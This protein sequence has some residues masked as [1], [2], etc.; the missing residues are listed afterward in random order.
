ME[1]WV[2]IKEIKLPGEFSKNPLSFWWDFVAVGH[3]MNMVQLSGQ[4][5]GSLFSFMGL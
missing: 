1:L 4:K 3:E 2:N 5:E